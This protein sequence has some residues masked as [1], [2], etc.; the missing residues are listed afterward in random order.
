MLVGLR[1]SDSQWAVDIVNSADIKPETR[2]LAPYLFWC[3]VDERREGEGAA[4]LGLMLLGIILRSLSLQ[5]SAYGQMADSIAPLY[6][7]DFVG[8]W[9]EL[10]H[11]WPERPQCEGTK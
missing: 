4:G 2:M 3:Q 10:L 7:P 5:P 8:M 1:P 11:R 9:I 6:G